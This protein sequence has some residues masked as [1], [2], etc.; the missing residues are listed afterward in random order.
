[1][2]STAYLVSTLVTGLV[3]VAVG[4]YVARAFAWRSWVRATG[5]GVGSDDGSAPELPGETADPS[6]APLAVGGVL[7]VA[8][9]AGV[10]AAVVAETP[11]LGALFGLFAGLLAL[12]V[13]WGVYHI[14]R[15]RGMTYAQ[16]FGAGIWLLATVFLAGIVAKLLV[17]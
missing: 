6:V 8:A 5:A 4:A 1:M 14:C 13:T 2:A 7:V 17:G 11:A 15:S 10:G 16:A 3:L 12:Y 9:G